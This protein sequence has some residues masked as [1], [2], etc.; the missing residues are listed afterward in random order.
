MTIKLR[1]VIISAIFR[2]TRPDQATPQET[3]AVLAA[4]TAAET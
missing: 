2:R 1:R 3:R 4:W